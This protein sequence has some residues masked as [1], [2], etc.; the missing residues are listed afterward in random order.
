MKGHVLIIEDETYCRWK[1]AQ[2]A[3]NPCYNVYF[4]ALRRKI[5]RSA[6]VDG[7]WKIGMPE[8]ILTLDE[9]A[10]PI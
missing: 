2:S 7:G 8:T 3:S 9:L 5:S 4:M 6:D 10:H 1:K